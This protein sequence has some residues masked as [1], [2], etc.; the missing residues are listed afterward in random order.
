MLVLGIES[1]T[2]VAS[3]A[4]ADETGLLGEI[5]LNVGLTHSEQLLPMI[6]SLLGQCR[7][8]IREVTAIG[9][10]AG[11]GS[12]TGLRIGMATAKALVQGLSGVGNRV[13]LLAIPTLEVMAWTLAGVPALVS[14]MLNARREQIYTG[15]YWWREA[16]T[17]MTLEL[18]E[19]IADAAAEAGTGVEAESRRLHA[20]F[21][22]RQR[23]KKDRMPAGVGDRP[24][25]LECLI[26]PTAI[27]PEDWAARLNT[28]LLDS[29]QNS[30]KM[31]SLQNIQNS[32]DPRSA[33]RMQNP[34]CIINIL[35]DGGTMYRE[36]W[37]RD[38]PGK[39]RLWP[40]AAGL[41]RGSYVALAAMDALLHSGIATGTADAS[42][43]QDEQAFYTT[44]P[45][46]LRGI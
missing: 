26:P 46:Y 2:P 1:A 13:R 28:Y 42:A 43:S 11:P 24:W 10:S 36:I 30:Q 14:P 29:I 12:F 22:S 41:C 4:L 17:T 19:A 16:E 38:L 45:I 37:E 40:P 6:D 7:R 44:K 8:K 23:G 15:L 18:E 39:T 27:S 20:L 21:A 3:V 33:Q 32:Q 35:G 5:T 9:V 31:Q 25:A 34:E